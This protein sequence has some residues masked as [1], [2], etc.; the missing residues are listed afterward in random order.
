MEKAQLYYA[1]G[2]MIPILPNDG[3]VF[4]LKELQ[5]LVGGKIEVIYFPSGKRLV[6]NEEG[7][8]MN[9]PMNT[10]VMEIWREEFPIEEYPD[11]N[12]GVVVG[13]AVICT[14]EQLGEG[15]VE[16]DDDGDVNQA[17]DMVDGNG[18]MI[19]MDLINGGE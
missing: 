15:E 2:K 3:K 4:N 9:L 19:D 8:L 14:P 10:Q 11:N 1:T 5:S 12:D 18:D 13:N 17:N 6:V 16:T 7:K